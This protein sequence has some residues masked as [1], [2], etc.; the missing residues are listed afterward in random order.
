MFE[1]LPGGFTLLFGFLFLS[2]LFFDKSKSKSFN[3][4][5]SHFSKNFCLYT[6]VFFFTLH[7]LLK[8][9]FLSHFFE[10]SFLFESLFITNLSVL[11]T[12]YFISKIFSSSLLSNFFLKLFCLLYSF[13]KREVARCLHFSRSF[14]NHEK[15]FLEIFVIHVAVN[16]VHRSFDSFSSSQEKS[17]L[18]NRFRESHVLKHLGISWF[19]LI[20]NSNHDRFFFFRLFLCHFNISEFNS[21]F[22]SLTGFKVGNFWVFLYMRQLLIDLSVSIFFSANLY[23]DLIVCSSN[24]LGGVV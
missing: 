15:F 8:S 24:H 4:F 13:L 20:T 16:P 19:N 5:I 21:W 1:L 14:S 17:F 7:L 11:F 22:E 9:F 3:S 2:L 23:F 12:L 10:Y 6:L 18:S